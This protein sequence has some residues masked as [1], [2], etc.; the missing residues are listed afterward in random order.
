MEFRMPSPSVVRPFLSSSAALC[1]AGALAHLAVPL[2]GPR[3][4]LLLGAPPQLAALAEEGALRPLLTCL[5]IASGLLVMAGYGFSHLGLLRPWPLARP[6]MGLFGL[7]LLV[8]GLAF[9]LIAAIQPQN[10][11][12]L[13]GRCEGLNVFV[14]LTSLLCLLIAVGFLLGA[15]HPRMQ[16]RWPSASV[17]GSVRG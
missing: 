17:Q 5:L 4:Y 8:R 11:A 6:L 7:A 10:L 13:C 2:M 9:P 15:A 12:Q 3:G 1:V 16:A 14:L